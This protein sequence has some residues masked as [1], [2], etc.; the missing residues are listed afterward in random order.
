LGNVQCIE[1]FNP[2]WK[3]RGT[4]RECQER[5]NR[6]LLDNLLQTHTSVDLLETDTAETSNRPAVYFACT[7]RDV[8]GDREV[9]ACSQYEVTREE[10]CQTSAVQCPI[11]IA[12]RTIPAEVSCFRRCGNH[13]ARPNALLHTQ[14]KDGNSADRDSALL[15]TQV[16]SDCEVQNSNLEGLGNVQCI[17]TF[18][19]TWKCKGTRRECQER[20]NR[21]LL[22]D[23]LQTHASVDLLET[24]TAE[25]SDRPAVYFACTSRDVGGGREVAA[26]SQY[27]VTREEDCQTSAVQCPIMIA[28]RTIPAEVSCFRRCGNH[29]ARTNALLHTQVKD[30][31]PPSE[32]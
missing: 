7:S 22:D 11:M 21:R 32:R 26:C 20:T 17:E 28:G 19:P 5:T 18:N 15:D 25:T 29:H 23:L 8:G 6:R 3:C 16:E 30:E 27:E 31:R 9:A 24:D 2:T 13:H 12:G 14:V 4:R 1:T 10:D